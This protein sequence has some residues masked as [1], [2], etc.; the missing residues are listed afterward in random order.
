MILVSDCAC[1]DKQAKAI[2]IHLLFWININ[3]KRDR[4]HEDLDFVFS[5]KNTSGKKYYGVI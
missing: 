1:L 5:Q 3:I 4:L 2:K